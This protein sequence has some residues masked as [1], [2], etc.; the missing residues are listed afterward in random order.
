MDH[1]FCTSHR[2]YR[3]F[4][5]S[6]NMTSSISLPHST[7]ASSS[8][9]AH[10]DKRWRETN[11]YEFSCTPRNPSNLRGAIIMSCFITAAIINCTKRDRP[12]DSG[13]SGAWSAN[14]SSVL[15]PHHCWADLSPVGSRSWQ[16]TSEVWLSGDH[17]HPLCPY[18]TRNPSIINPSI[19]FAFSVRFHP[20]DTCGETRTLFS[21]K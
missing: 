19:L 7:L 10:P 13:D 8:M 16:A 21:Q 6:W 9:L 2:A 17:P 12:C 3:C 20:R 11:N 18:H 14:G 1:L 15:P 4:S 5:G